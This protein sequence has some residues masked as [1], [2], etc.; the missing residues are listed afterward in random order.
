MVTESTQLRTGIIQSLHPTPRRT[1][2]PTDWPDSVLTLTVVREGDGVDWLW[3]KKKLSDS[4]S[5]RA[6]A[7]NG[8]R[9]PGGPAYRHRCND[10]TIATPRCSTPTMRSWKKP[11]AFRQTPTAAAAAAVTAA[12]STVG[13]RCN[14]NIVYARTRLVTILL[15][16]ACGTS[17]YANMRCRYSLLSVFCRWFRRLRLKRMR[18]SRSMRKKITFL[19]NVIYGCKL[20]N[21]YNVK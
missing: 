2:R 7:K 8:L 15:W 20:V 11:E 13:M 3:R 16:C 12:A 19:I 5:P 4:L 14:N 1:D 17:H 9:P 6:R 21:N 18:R 10:E